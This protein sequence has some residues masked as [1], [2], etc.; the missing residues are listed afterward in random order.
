MLLAICYL[1]FLEQN[2]LNL[3][4]WWMSMTNTVLGSR[5][6][7]VGKIDVFPRYIFLVWSYCRNEYKCKITNSDNWYCEEK[8]NVFWK[9]IRVSPIL[10]TEEE[11][12]SGTIF[13]KWTFNQCQEGWPKAAHTQKSHSTEDMNMIENKKEMGAGWGGVVKHRKTTMAEGG[14]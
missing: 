14:E 3:T 8:H 1:I 10:I 12:N 5:I 9:E 13:R 2:I 4:L 6:K 11:G 7:R